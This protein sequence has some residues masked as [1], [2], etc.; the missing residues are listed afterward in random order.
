M[1]LKMGE[2]ARTDERTNERK[3]PCVLQDIVPF[4]AAAQKR[5]RELKVEL[6]HECASKL[7][8]K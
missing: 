3:A 5:E 4:G 6:R 7:A 8:I 2:H 1:S